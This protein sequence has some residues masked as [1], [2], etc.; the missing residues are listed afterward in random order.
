MA[1]IHARVS[2]TIR[3]DTE[4]LSAFSFFLPSSAR[5]AQQTRR[6]RKSLL[7]GGLADRDTQEDGRLGLFCWPTEMRTI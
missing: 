1:K 6:R 5:P 4:N 3:P 2:D 7:A